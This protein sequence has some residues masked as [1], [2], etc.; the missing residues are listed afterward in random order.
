[1]SSITAW[2]PGVILPPDKLTPE[3]IEAIKSSLYPAQVVGLTAWAEA[4]SRYVPGH[5]WL[6]NPIDALVDV[7]NVIHNRA[8]DARWMGHGYAGICLARWQFSCWEPTGGPDD[9]NDPD[10]LAENFEALMERAQ[11]LLAGKTPT[12]KLEASIHVADAFIQGRHENLLGIGVTHYI[13]AWLDPWPAW[14]RGHTPVLG[15]HGHLFFSGI[16]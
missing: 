10:H 6:P 5:G 2:H 3:I 14:A 16:V 4:R 7:V 12:S 11:L 13:A 8:L 15:R 1:M 9:P